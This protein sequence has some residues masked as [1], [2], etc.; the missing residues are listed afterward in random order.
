M[1]NL[2][3]NPDDPDCDPDNTGPDSGP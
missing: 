3:C 2:Y 1:E